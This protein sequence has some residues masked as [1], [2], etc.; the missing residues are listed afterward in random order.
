MPDR[1]DRQKAEGEIP[2]KPK[3][4]GHFFVVVVV[5]CED[6]DM[7]CVAVRGQRRWGLS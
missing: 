5:A 1:G 6:N 2:P 7:A 4:Q 3:L